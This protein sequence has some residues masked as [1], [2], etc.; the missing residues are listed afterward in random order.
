MNG[1]AVSAMMWMPKLKVVD[2]SYCR[3]SDEALIALGD[4][5]H[6]IRELNLHYKLW[7]HRRG[8]GGVG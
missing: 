6:D 4:R 3:V 1:T 2:L 5:C 8:L 7:Y